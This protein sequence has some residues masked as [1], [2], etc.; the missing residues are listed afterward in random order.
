MNFAKGPADMKIIFAVA[1]ALAFSASGLASFGEEPQP[2]LITVAC[3]GDSITAGSG[4]T[5]RAGY[6]PE[7][8]GTLLGKR[9]EVKNFGVGGTCVRKK[10]WRPYLT[11]PTLKTALD[12]KP[13]IVVIMLGVN[14]LHAINS[15]TIVEFEADYKELIECFKSVQ[16]KPRIYLCFPTPYG[17]ASA[18]EMVRETIRQLA[19]E[20]DCELID[21][22]T[23]L[24]DKPQFFPD[25]C[26]PN[27][28]GARVI[29]QEVYR[30]LVNYTE[31]PL[32]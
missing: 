14:D 28:D 32:K 18:R 3:I 4:I 27:A 30:V 29:A 6:Y 17:S 24:C 1:V 5:N 19:E 15:E 9:W 8:L 26:H 23:P 11:W 25:H 2:R 16:G 10:G 20:N 12:Y 31:E 22:Y 7:V 21:M 13:G